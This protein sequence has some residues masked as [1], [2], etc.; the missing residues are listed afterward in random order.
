MEIHY[1]VLKRIIPV[2]ILIIVFGV[3]TSQQNDQ[4]PIITRKDNGFYFTEQ[5]S[6]HTNIRYGHLRFHLNI[7]ELKES[8]CHI[9]DKAKDLSDII[10]IVSTQKL[11]SGSVIS[12][13]GYFDLVISPIKTLLKSNCEAITKKAQMMMDMISIHSPQT[14]ESLHRL[15]TNATRNK[16]SILAAALC[17]GSLIFG[18]YN[19]IELARL[20]SK[21]DYI[22]ERQSHLLIA[23]DNIYQSIIQTDEFL[24]SLNKTT[25]NL[26]DALSSSNYEH[27]LFTAA[28][29][30]LNIQRYQMQDVER[31][32]EG[33]I[34][35][36]GGKL[37]QGLVHYDALKSSL[38]A[39]K[40]KAESLSFQL[41]VDSIRHL[42]EMEA[43]YLIYADE[44]LDFFIHI[45]LI[46]KNSILT[47]Y[48]YHEVPLTIN[49]E[50][51][52]KKWIIP[53]NMRYLAA[54]QDHSILYE[55]KENDLINCNK[56]RDT[57]YCKNSVVRRKKLQKG[58]VFQ[59]FSNNKRN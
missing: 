4:E 23:V 46:D 18:G 20:S 55:I 38:N 35:V 7:T 11:P 24:D 17:I 59:L 56:Y 22:E 33:V 29:Q 13:K 14:L 6:L 41:S 2:I 12:T 34:S 16:R 40:L 21:L 10:K 42:F 3:N 30:I 37:S 45:P 48:K 58:A 25:W 9:C 53:N 5:G 51:E 49:L 44:T 50:D 36:L 31:M 27:K 54:N 28:R 47:L 52:G 26:A 1:K 8:V 39:M 43:S 15:P 32:I 19:M 57:Y